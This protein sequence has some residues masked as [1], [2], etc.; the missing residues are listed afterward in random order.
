[1][2]S[3]LDRYWHQRK[4][5]RAAAHHA[6]PTSC[7]QTISDALACHHHAACS[8]KASHILMS[9]GH[10]SMILPRWPFFLLVCFT[11]GSL[12]RPAWTASSDNPKQ[13]LAVL[14]MSSCVVLSSLSFCQGAFCFVFLFYFILLKCIF[15]L[16][17]GILKMICY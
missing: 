2:A 11:S 13:L 5:P 3:G 7:H 12:R 15:V 9:V 17:S 1:M 14:T 4:W 10:Q 8:E 16:M 6:M